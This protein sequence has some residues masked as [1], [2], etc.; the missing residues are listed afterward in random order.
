MILD[1]LVT[2]PQ[3]ECDL[4]IAHATSDAGENFHLARR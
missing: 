4:F 2:D 1:R 3:V